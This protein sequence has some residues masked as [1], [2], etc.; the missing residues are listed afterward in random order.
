MYHGNL[1][2]V[3]TAIKKKSSVKNV[4]YV[5]PATLDINCRSVIQCGQCRRTHGSISINTSFDNRC[6]VLSGMEFRT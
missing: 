2:I 5:I 1:E 4:S 6:T 3:L